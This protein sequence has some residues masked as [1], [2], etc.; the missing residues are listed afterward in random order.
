[1][2]RCALFQR[3]PAQGQET[4]L[5]VDAHGKWQIANQNSE[6][7]LSNDDKAAR[8]ASSTVVKEAPD[9]VLVRHQL[10]GKGGMLADGQEV[11]E[12]SEFSIYR[13][14]APNSRHYR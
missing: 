4:G 12:L 11:P 1:M 5:Q 9:P 8:P 13:R 10:R 14:H 2:F 3:I 6:L 7:S